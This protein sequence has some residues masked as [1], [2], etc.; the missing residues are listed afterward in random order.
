MSSSESR[1]SALFEGVNEAV[2]FLK[3]V[4][5]DWKVDALNQ[6]ARALLHEIGSN[7]EVGDSFLSSVADI[8]LL[9]DKARLLSALDANESVESNIT[10]ERAQGRVT[11]HLKVQPIPGEDDSRL[12]LL[13]SARSLGSSHPWTESVHGS[14][15]QILRHIGE[16]VLLINESGE[17]QYINRE[18]EKLTGW[19][20]EEIHGESA[21]L[22][23][24]LVDSHS[25]DP[26][27]SPIKY[28]SQTGLPHGSSEGC[29]LLHR[30]GDSVP[31]QFLAM[32]VAGSATDSAGVLLVFRDD[33]PRLR[34]QKEQVNA[35]RLETINHLAGGIA[36]D[37]NNL[38]TGIMGH[39]ALLR[40]SALQGREERLAGALKAADRARSLSIQLLSLAKGHA[41]VLSASST[42]NLLAEVTEFSMAG[43]N[44]ELEVSLPD[45]LWPCVMDEGRVAQVLN[46]LIINA[47]QA[48]P[49]GGKIRLEGENLE[50]ISED[51]LPLKPGAFVRIKLEDEGPGIEPK[52]LSRIFDPYFTT[53]KQGSGLGLANC[54][55]IVR[56]HQG[57]LSVDSLVGKGTT[58]TLYLPATPEA[59]MEEVVEEAQVTYRGKGRVLVMDDEVLVQEIVIDILKHL[60][61]DP[62]VAS[63]GEEALEMVIRETQA[64][65]PFA[66]VIVDLT[67]PGSM[68]G[69]DTKKRLEEI[70]PD[71]PVIVSSGYSNDPVLVHYHEN[72]FAGVAVKPYNIQQ[73][74]SALKDA[75]VGQRKNAGQNAPRSSGKKSTS[76]PF[77]L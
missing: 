8:L 68:G 74:S 59:V 61:Y 53:K 49:E 24:R 16:G 33:N 57:H 15:N 39:L 50:V 26:L 23:F 9:D 54:K 1:F 3:R 28:V 30:Q 64:K 5:E 55:T 69:L 42:R 47:Q 67:V 62:E 27:P 18:G 58:F 65:K 4:D 66:A 36:H 44:S 40:E 6:P 48:M 10:L 20:L 63:N 14:L 13:D 77:H 34:L 72:G 31:L 2:L 71:L 56:Q 22:A 11:A 41:P 17:V 60:G 70:A 35:Q 52:H 29:H 38:L 32:P 73:M 75:I 21:E 76:G 51:G 45:E 7:G 25:R 12:L 46:N 19:S 37:F 43:S